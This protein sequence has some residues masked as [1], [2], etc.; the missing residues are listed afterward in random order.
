LVNH[1]DKSISSGGDPPLP[2][3]HLDPLSSPM[4]KGLLNKVDLFIK[5]KDIVVL[6]KKKHSRPV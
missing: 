4:K 6:E 2:L 5:K 1:E 3:H